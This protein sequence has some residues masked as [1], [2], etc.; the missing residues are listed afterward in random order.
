MRGSAKFFPWIFDGADPVERSAV[1]TMPPPP[2]RVL[3]QYVW[4]PRYQ[5]KVATLWEASS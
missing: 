2:V 4:E 5:R 3:C 1:L